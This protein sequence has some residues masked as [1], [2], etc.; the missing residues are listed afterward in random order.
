MLCEA[1]EAAV[2]SIK[3]PD[4]FKIEAMIDKII[5]QRIK[6]ILAGVQERNRW[7]IKGLPK[8]EGRVC[9]LQWRSSNGTG[10]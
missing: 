6:Q 3:D 2:R 4:I 5:Q 1:I 9:F 7:R 8:H 10:I